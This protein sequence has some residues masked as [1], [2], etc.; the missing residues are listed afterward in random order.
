MTDIFDAVREEFAFLQLEGDTILH[1]YVANTFKQLEQSSENSGPQKDVV[2]NDPTAKMRSSSGVAR[3]VQGFPFAFKNA[4]H[5]CVE[6]R[7][8]AWAKRHD[9]KTV[10]RVVR[11]KESKL[12]LVLETNRNLMVAG[13]VIQ[14]DEIQSAGGVAKVVDSVVAPGDGVFERKGDLVESTVRDTQAP[15][16]IDDVDDMFLV[17]FRGE[18]NG[19]APGAKAF[20]DP[21]IVL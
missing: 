16:K 4:H 6:S 12:L 7:G 17:R 1:E 13:F 11:C 19:G 5:T 21:T 3:S 18:D 14:S 9:A 10:F 8:V 20:T 15:N 2:D